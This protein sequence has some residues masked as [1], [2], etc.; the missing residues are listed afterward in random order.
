MNQILE[1]FLN[2]ILQTMAI[3]ALVYLA[4]RA[5]PTLNAATRYAVWCI[6]LAAVLALPILYQFKPSYQP[7]RT[8]VKAGLAKP[9]GLT[10]GIQVDPKGSIP[11]LTLAWAA[12]AGLMMLHLATSYAALRRLKSSASALPIEAPYCRR[13]LRIL[14]SNRIHSPISVG[15]LQPAIIVP[16]SLA[17]R[18]T[19]SEL[20]GVLIHEY[21]HLARRD[22][23]TNLA[24]RLLQAPL[25]FH[26]IV[27]FILRQQALERELACDDWVV[28]RTGNAAAYAATLLKLTELRCSGNEPTLAT[29][30]LG[31]KSHF[32]HRIEELLSLGRQFAPFAS[33]PRMAIFFLIVATLSFGALLS[34]G[35]VQLRRPKVFQT[36]A[37]AHF[38]APD[39]GFL[40]GLKDAGYN[41]LD[42]DE[43]IELKNNGVRPKYI[44]DVTNLMGKISVPEL[45]QLNR[46][47]VNASDIRQS[48]KLQAD[49][50]V[51]QIIKFK[52]S[53]VL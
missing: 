43:I 36:A 41:H 28:H 42:V 44:A 32:A 53:G 47:G 12:G 35:L 34:P 11:W 5:I 18:L 13:S 4:L 22:D 50:T 48:Q 51:D 16:V 8:F 26:P 17:T 21:A 33:R 24:G 52:T 19:A 15:Y 20:D 45:V 38:I 2:T 7:I 49:V 40:A 46:H 25:W 39:K 27:W 23:W 1:A 31:R 29:G 37:R 9:L 10:H 3:T 14:V 30:I 6:T